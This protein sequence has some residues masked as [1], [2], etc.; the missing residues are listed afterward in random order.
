[1]PPLVAEVVAL[2]HG[3]IGLDV[4]L[5]EAGYVERVLQLLAGFDGRVVVTS[6]LDQVI[7]DVKRRAP[8]GSLCT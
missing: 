6:F 8:S 4:E 1:M 5:K 7:G 3:R 2:A